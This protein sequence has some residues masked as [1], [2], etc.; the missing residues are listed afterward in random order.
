M[1]GRILCFITECSSQFMRGTTCRLSKTNAAG[2]CVRIVASAA[3]LFCCQCCQTNVEHRNLPPRWPKLHHS[4]H[5]ALDSASS[6]WFTT[7]LAS[8][9]STYQQCAPRF[10]WQVMLQSPRH[11]CTVHGDPFVSMRPIMRVCIF[12]TEMVCNLGYICLTPRMQEIVLM[13]ITAGC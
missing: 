11:R 3:A 4:V 8:T 9:R 6:T 5:L 12:H 13:R 2:A 10:W 1:A 7:S